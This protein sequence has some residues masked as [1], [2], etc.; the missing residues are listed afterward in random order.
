MFKIPTFIKFFVVVI[1]LAF[2]WIRFVY[3]D[4][5]EA[6]HNINLNEEYNLDSSQ[7]KEWMD[8]HTT[9][10]VEHLIQAH[11]DEQV[12]LHGAEPLTVNFSPSDAEE[13]DSDEKSIKELFKK[14]FLEKILSE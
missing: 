14:M 12:E 1:I 8:T 4:Y 9:E 13:N 3:P 10:E 11:I 5:S 7:V 2:L 6:G